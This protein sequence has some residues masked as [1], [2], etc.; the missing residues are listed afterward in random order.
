[1]LSLFLQCIHVQS[2]RVIRYTVFSTHLLE[3][4]IPLLKVGGTFVALKGPGLEEELNSSSNALKKL[5]CSIHKVIVDVL[6]ECGETRNIIYITKNKST[7]SKYPRDYKDI[8][9]LPL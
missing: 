4:C 2:C 5:N 1:M 7:H 6:P 9:K 8:K 3:L